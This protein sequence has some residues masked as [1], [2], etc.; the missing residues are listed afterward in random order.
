MLVW[1]YGRPLHRHGSAGGSVGA[2][3]GEKVYMTQVSSTVPSLGVWRKSTP[4]DEQH[5]LIK[6]TGVVL[7]VKIVRTPGCQGRNNVVLE[8]PN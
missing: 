6:D 8:F 1:E 5:L 7:T 2:S 4:V 3:Q